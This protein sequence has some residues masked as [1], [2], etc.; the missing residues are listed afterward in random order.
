[1]TPEARSRLVGY[2]RYGAGLMLV[3]WIACTGL[4][5][6]M[7]RQEPPVAGA[8]LQRLP[9]VCWL[10]FPLKIMWTQAN[11][12]T[13]AIGDT[14]P[15]FDLPTIDGAQHVKLSS[16]RGKPVVL[17]FGSYTCHPFRVRMPD[18][19]TLYDPY[20]DRAQFYFIYIEEAHPTDGWNDPD[21][22]KDG[23]AFPNARSLQ[24]RVKVGG[25]C[26]KGMKIPFPTLADEMDNHVGRAYNAWPIRVYI[27]DKDGKVAFKSVA[28]PFGF[29]IDQ[30]K[31]ELQRLLGPPAVAA[32]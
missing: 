26:A 25:A 31:P 9:D 27:V 23:A 1:M 3:L 19:N 12:G 8:F 7:M 32:S 6:V 20:K 28:G 4:I 16:L 30:V 24:E 5:F 10:L 14:A 21:N 22:V 29:M 13:L 15:D 11:R 2:A 17:F 18:M